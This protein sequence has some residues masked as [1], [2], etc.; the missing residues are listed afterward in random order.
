MDKGK[1]M[2]QT[3]WKKRLLWAAVWAAG[4]VLAAVLA[5]AFLFRHELKTLTTLEKI[6]DN[7]L[8]TMKYDGDY[9]F[10]DFLLTGASTDG[11]LVRFVTD[12][13]LRGLP[14]EFSIPDLGCSTF[15]AWTEDGDRIFGRNFDLTYSPALVVET[16][17]DNGYRSISTVNLAF[18]GFGEDKLPDTWKQKL[19][20]L[21]AP[22][23]PLDGINEKGLAVAVL[24]I[25]DEPTDQDTGK[26]DIT[27]TTAIRLMLDKAATV[28]EAVSLLEQYDMH[29]SAGSCY[30]FQLADAAGDSA[31]VE[32]IDNEF[33]VL[34]ADEGYQMATNFLLSDK[35]FNFGNGQD[36]YEILESSLNRC[37]GVVKDEQAGMDL[38]QAASKDWHVSETSG[39]LNATQWSIVFNCTDLTAKVVTGRQYDK[40]AH[41]FSLTQ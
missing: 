12:R 8:Y 7:V 9:G 36:R 34:K 13:L 22:Y 1:I 28:D 6:D 18:L 40:P 3:R 24:R 11:E 29:S 25:A 33:V 39:R 32:Y 41:T 4:I 30:H 23:A 21:A 26:M 2:T 10:D 35:K 15:S 17:P 16:A 14:L 37:G 5:G 31:V 38:L 27:T 20:T 19:I